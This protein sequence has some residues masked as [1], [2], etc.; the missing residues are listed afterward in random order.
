MGHGGAGSNARTTLPAGLVDKVW[1]NPGGLAVLWAEEN[2]RD[3]LF[4]AMRRKEAYATSGTRIVLRFFAGSQLPEDLCA[5]P[6]FVEQGY[7]KGVPMGG[8]LPVSGDEPPRFAVF[9]QRDPGAAGDPGMPLQRIQIIKGWVEGDQVKYAIHDVAGDAN[10]GASVDEATCE[11]KGA[12]QDELCGVWT[13]ADFDPSQH[14]FYYARV[15]ENPSCRWHAR[16]CAAAGVT[17]NLLGGA[18]KNGFEG[19]CDSAYPKAHQERAWSSPI[20][21]RAP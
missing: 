4:D 11:T 9:A 7:A 16:Q 13:D 18:S 10:N 1:L 5:A 15:L 2:S 17:C 3:S 19:C 14:A 6:D 21:H 20:F 8:Q 12:G